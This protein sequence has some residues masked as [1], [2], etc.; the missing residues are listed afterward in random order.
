MHK[1]LRFLL[2]PCILISSIVFT[3]ALVVQAQGLSFPAEINKS[4]SPISIAAGEISRLNITIFNPNSFQ[5]DNAAWTDNLIGVQPGILLANPVNLSNTCG[6]AV[7]AVA[8]TTSLSL[9]GG[10]VPAQVG[11]TPGSCTVAVDVTSTTPGNLINTIPIN[12]LTS[13]GGG[14]SIT[15]TTRASA[16]LRVGAVQA[17]S[18]RKSFTPNTVWVGETSR[19]AIVIRNNDLNTALT[20]TSITDNLPAG[21][22]LASPVSPT[23]TNCGGTASLSAISGTGLVT[24]SNSTIAPNTSCAIRV[25]VISTT[26][27]I[28]NNTI[29]ATS[30][31]TRQGVTNA[32]PASAALN[33]Q[34]IGV[35][36]AFSPTDFQ[37]GG[38]STLIITLQNPTGS[39]YTGVN[40]ADTLPVVP[41]NNL[42]VVAGSATT[43][44]G[45]AVSA[46]LPRTV[47]LTGGTIPA[48][49][50]ATPGTC[51]INVQV[52]S[53]AGASAVTYM[54]TIPA[55]AMTTNQGITN[56]VPATANVSVY[57]T[58]TGVIG[59][60]SFDPATINAGD[61]SMLRI[62]INAPADTNL[63]NFSITDNLPANVIVSNSS[64]A[65]ATGC[66]AAPVLTAVTGATSISLTNGTIL[67]GT[68]CTID[69]WVTSSTPGVHTNIIPPTNITNNENRR[70]VNDLTADLTVQPIVLPSD[71]S[72]S[73]AFTP[74]TVTPNGLSTLTITLQNTNSLP[75][76]NVSLA[77][78]LPGGTMNGIVIAPIP[79]ATT[80]CGSGI[81]T[82][83]SGGKTI[84]MANGSIPAQ[85]GIIPGVCTINVDVQ[86]VGGIN[87]HA[88]TIPIGDVSG[89]IQGTGTIISN[90]D[91]ATA[92]LTITN[93]SIG[94]VKGFNPLT[95]FGGSAS[96]M[97]VQLVNPNN[98][99]L[100]GIAFTDNMPAG[101]IIANPPNLSIGTC[102][103]TLTGVSGAG[104][105]S[106]SGGSLPA[107]TSCT[108]TLSVTMTVNGNLT[109]TIPAGA[110]TTFNG[111]SSPQ[112]AEASLTNLPGAS[113]SKV[114]APNPIAAG[115]GNYS[116]LTITIQ[117][118]GN[119]P[120]TGMGLSDA[121]PG[122]L[123]AGL[124]IAGAPAPAPVNTCGGTLSAVPGTQTIQLTNGSLAGSSSCTIVVSVTG[125]TP[126]DYQNTIPVGALTSAQ[127][128][129]NNQPATDTLTLTGGPTA[130]I[131]D[132][133]WNDLNANG[134]QDAGE[135]GIPNVTVNLLN[136][137][138]TVLA[139]TTTNASGLYSFTNLTPGIYGVEFVPPAGYAISS[140]N[141]GA[142]DAVD[143][144]ANIG[145]G[146]TGNYTLVAG[147]TNN[148]VD[149]GLYQLAELGDYV[150]NDLNAN[151]IQDAGESGINGVTVNL[152]TGTGAFVTTTTTAGGGLYLFSGLTPGDYYVEFVQPG[153]YVFSSQDQGGNDGLD[154]DVNTATGRTVTTTLVGGE[155]DLSWD[156]GLYSQQGL[157]KSV[158]DTNQ[159][160]TTGIFDVAIGE[161]ITYQVSLVI[162]PGTFS[163]AS[164]ADTMQR[165]LAFVGCDSI[166]GA[167]LITDLSGGFSAAC[168]APTVDDAGGGGVP[169]GVDADRRV[170]FN[171]GTVTNS[172]TL[173]ATLTFTY[174]A[175]VLDIAS[176]IDGTP[177]SNS[178]S[179]LWGNG[180]SLGP[181]AAIVSIVEPEL[182]IDKS[183]NNNF[184]SVGT[185]VTFTLVGT[186]TANSHT[187]AF[188]VVVTD[189]L[190][191]EFDFVTG[192]LT[193]NTGAQVTA[194]CSYNPATR[195]ITAVWTTFTRLGGDLRVQFKVIG[196]NLLV[197]GV[198]VTNVG[199]IE[200]TSLPGP[201]KI[202]QSYSP[203][204]HSTER[205][206]DPVDTTGVNNYG[207]N[208]SLVLNALGG[209]GD[210]DKEGHGNRN[211]RN[212]Q[213]I[214]QGNGG[215]LIPI[216]GFAPGLITDLSGLPVARYDANLDLSL[217]IPRLKLVMPIVGAPLKNGAWDVN[218]LT[219]Q[220]GW[221]E[222]TAFPGFPGNS[223]LTGHVTSSYGVAG[224][225]ASL[226]KLQEGDLIFVHTFGQTQIYKV[227]TVKKVQPNEISVLDH[228]E[229]PWLTLL[230]CADYNEKTNKYLSRVVVRAE[231]IEVRSGN[232]NGR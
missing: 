183:V 98:A 19:L 131:G 5:L 186:H 219:N 104:S 47:T 160:F 112:P 78:A 232:I 118:T 56:I 65:I 163:N 30:V 44:C 55:G 228:Q 128:A 73:K 68:P 157:T 111:A 89:E 172:G 217:E 123:P 209:A 190:P 136:A 167:G 51:T 141:Q 212:T 38:T 122:T 203:N 18:L 103:G 86:G 48:G 204:N 205:Y 13:T 162:P 224:P 193:C 70:P 32:S 120:L 145:T 27:N 31:Q 195:T 6:G 153:G 196:N 67:I 12:G 166:N 8:G 184:I 71:L 229:K 74:P 225:F 211:N 191:T 126:G 181:V 101:M 24:L 115:L 106:F 28:Y 200:W 91:P 176:N 170:T 147:E 159:T 57:A 143:S 41:N 194:N 201:V 87:A 110:V 99:L 61:N 197:P 43:T 142:N 107:N 102:G 96:T 97:S 94:V 175:V 77:D 138:G 207:T 169:I 180:S 154:S 216:T 62:N 222:K 4:F 45:G 22:I 40:I 149:A 208:D 79:N 165:G 133:V 155:N 130:S 52:T 114:F 33:V 58:G 226:Y 29:P 105:F 182:A 11:T 210:G 3:P 9:S 150:W 16:T 63:T 127:G 151:G 80:T 66:G 53:P 23:L 36:K 109:N 25:D 220:A 189:I 158:S 124:E 192:S 92:R 82:A 215:F 108:L 95:V 26:T 156:A 64:P 218:W 21:V 139:T 35:A 152:Y 146:R 227:R 129:T 14:G 179:F 100:T 148:S 198:P 135:S 188:D 81:I 221:L 213:D 37:A 90:A 7:T 69:V 17:P 144:D 20:Q 214:G 173:D 121:L 10:T 161:I 140:A 88:N 60:K 42:T 113:V 46:T 93:L 59:S 54:N 199:S 84:Q 174:R 187:D 171:L 2:L 185:E 125:S 168:S 132:Y 75:L 231:L 134:I 202:P 15:N 83:P 164:L 206:Y 119:I 223:V 137:A 39:A 178:A 1:L 85:V 50:V 76:V 72:V 116:L 117:N 230:T 34:N 177:L 49:T